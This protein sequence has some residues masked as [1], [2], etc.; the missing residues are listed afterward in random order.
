MFFILITKNMQSPK[1]TYL[2]LRVVL[3]VIILKV[4]FGL[5]CVVSVEW[6]GGHLEVFF[7]PMCVVYV[8]WVGGH[9]DRLRP[10]YNI[11]MEVFELHFV[12]FRV[13][14]FTYL[15][16]HKIQISLTQSATKS[17]MHMKLK[18]GKVFLSKP[19]S[20]LYSKGQLLSEENNILQNYSNYHA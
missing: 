12:Y 13:L 1:H 7:G 17:S 9:R 11:V 3:F 8:G 18:F 20:F 10:T 5:V 16:V 19:L 4:L 6:A 2:Y 15:Y 14:G